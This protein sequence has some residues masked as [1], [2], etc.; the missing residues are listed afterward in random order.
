MS[1]PAVKARAVKKTA[2]ETRET[3]SRLDVINVPLESLNLIEANAG[4]GKTWTITALYLRLLLEAERS[5]DA[6]LVV[7]FTEAATA[8]LRD[9][10]RNRIV[11]ARAAFESGHGDDD[12]LT[13]LLERIADRPSALL[14]LTRALRE[15][16]QAPIY[17]IH[18]FCQRVLGDS[19]F[20]S[21]MP[22]RTEILV[23]Q[24]ALLQEI[25]E[26]FWRS[27]IASASP[28]F[29]RYL[30][31]KRLR[32]DLLREDIER[33]VGK[34]YVRIDC[35]DEPQDVAALEAAYERAF[36][37]ARVIW[38][39]ERAAIAKQLVDNPV[40][41]GGRY[42]RDS[43]VSWLE[44]MHDCLCPESAGVELCKQFEKF[45]P[46]V[47]E[48]ST[49]SGKRPPKHVFYD[50]CAM[51]KVAHDGLIQAYSRR[52]PILK[53]RLLEY[54]NGELAVRKQRKQLQSYDDLLLNL[55]HALQSERGDELV[56]RVRVRY[57]AALIDEFQDTDPVQYAIFRRLYGKSDLPV[58]FVGD[59]KQSIYSFRGA[60]VYAYLDART[61]AYRQHTLDVNWRSEPLLLTAVN[62]IFQNAPSPF[63]I[64]GIPFNAS[65]SAPGD[66][67]HLVVEEE[68]R[69]PFEIWFAD[70]GADGKPLAKGAMRE[71]AARATAV[72]IARLLNRGERGQARIVWERDERSL[73]GGDIAVLVR[74]H[75]QA[76]AVRD[77][78]SAVGVA[79]VQRGSQNVFA[80][81]QAEEL[82]RVLLA[83]AEPAREQLIG[84]AL[85][86]ELMGYSGEALYSLRADE[87]AWEEK[88]ETFREAHREWRERGFIPMLRNFLHRYDVVWRLLQYTDGERR[89]TNLRHLAE[90]LHCDG[91]RQG[92]GGLLAWLSAKRK[93][94][95][96]ANV[97]ELLRLESD[98]NLVKILT[99]H[100][101][102][103]LEF[104]VVFCPFLWDGKLW[105]KSED[106]LVFH[107]A[108]TRNAVVDFGSELLE[109]NREQAMLEER[110]ENMRLLYVALTRAKYRCCM[111]W[112][113]VN[114]AE[115]SAPA[116]LLKGSAAQTDA[117]SMRDDVEKLQASSKGAIAVVDLPASADVR[118]EPANATDAVLVPRSFTAQIH[119]TRRV[120]SFT[121]LAHGRALEAPD[122]DATPERDSELD[123]V[124]GGRDIFA[125][126]RGAQAGK[127][128]H[129]IFEA[130]DFVGLARPE[131]DRVVARE[132]LTYGFEKE[133]RDVVADTMQRVL[134][135]PL[136]ES[137]ELR[138]DRVARSKRLDELEFYYPLANLSH[139][140]VRQI[141]LA[142]GFPDQIKE[143]IGEL[144]FAPLQGYMRGFIDLVFEHAGRYYLVDY[145]SNWLGPTINSYQS[146]ALEKAMGREAYYLQYL[147]YCVAL[148]RYLRLRVRGYEYE[149]HFGGV[150][151]LFL[152]GMHPKAGTTRGVY[153]DTPPRSL[154]EALDRYLDKGFTGR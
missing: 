148:H 47:L 95:G 108:R 59:P 145:K 137:G 37:Q 75:D 66:R 3:V 97:E 42:R 53:A 74:S 143:R 68:N 103:G 12:L 93:A 20:E 124:G 67:G 101:A 22:F 121:G 50:A 112:G 79:S 120:T 11:E 106:V 56:A 38:L 26:D 24:T 6:I 19:A 43:V 44:Q 122:Y 128:L 1:S 76:A 116:W 91:D 41:H 111:A 27:D 2:G 107:D 71:L 16:D 58:F 5:V 49:K 154:I 129:A 149:T 130:I 105:A 9:R 150:R 126:P 104:P 82:E 142:S 60:D 54:A 30:V 61:D 88:V 65:Q 10:I 15:F 70:G 31:T 153:S 72:E 102:K 90:R 114:E 125:F 117:R 80:T 23:D 86:T 118:F 29:T 132:L 18:A 123:E 4:T 92:M 52:L 32:P 98:E 33:H 96:F 146:D 45:T 13:A 100:V 134:A 28:L 110:A 40:L 140:G 55:L 39:A 64:D 78:L 119:D 63:V 109:Q 151:Y 69:A 99:I 113:N 21:G 115:T 34:P 147:V 152:R 17:T 48:Q 139:S 8:E 83:I 84:A 127:C 85:V 46:A 136:D 135:T 14:R 36:G 7:T 141:L 144:T 57:P 89:V 81:A 51:L 62:A 35:P 94:P 133:W 77:A 87:S 131:L 25:V 138:L 73:K